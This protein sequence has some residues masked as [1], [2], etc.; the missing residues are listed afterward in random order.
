[1]IEDGSVLRSKGDDDSPDTNRL[2]IIWR[3]IEMCVK[4][5]SSQD[6]EQI[7]HALMRGYAAISNAP[8]DK[9]ADDEGGKRKKRSRSKG[10]ACQECIPL[11]L[12]LNPA[13]EDGQSDTGF[14]LVLN[15]SGA[16]AMHHIFHFSERLRSEWVKCFVRVYDQ[17]HL[18]KIAND[19]LGSRW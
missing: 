16:R 4:K 17:E 11:M 6:Q 15:A 1:M 19:G 5:G 7:I 18:V 8:D 12:G 2:G 9:E 3:A 14:R 10:L 13:S